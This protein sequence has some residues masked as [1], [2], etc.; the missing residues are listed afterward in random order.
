MCGIVTD[1]DIVVRALA[2]GRKASHDPIS[3]IMSRM[4]VR[5]FE[6]QPI[7]EAS[8]LMAEH[9][10]R[11]LP[12]LDREG[13]LRGIVSLSDIHGGNQRQLRRGAQRAADDALHCQAGQQDE[14]RGGGA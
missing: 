14:G 8:Q 13:S 6:D 9:G 4:L 2:L 1:R 7:E 10:V 5:C 11:R 12:V 3:R